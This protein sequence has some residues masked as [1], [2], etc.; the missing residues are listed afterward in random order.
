[1]LECAAAHHSNLLFHQVGKVE[2]IKH[3]RTLQHVSFP[4]ALV[5]N[6]LLHLVL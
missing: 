4:H 1:M 5:F 3:L 2:G 6:Q